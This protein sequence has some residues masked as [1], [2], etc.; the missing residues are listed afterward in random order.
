MLKRGV[1]LVV[2]LTIFSSSALALTSFDLNSNSATLTVF[3]DD[4]ADRSGVSVATG[5]VNND[6]FDD[7]IIGAYLA[8][9][10]G[11]GSAGE[12]YII[13]GSS[14]SP[15]SID[16][17][18]VSA[19]VTI[20]GDDAGDQSGQAVASGDVNN[21][22]FADV[23]IGAEFGDG[24]AGTLSAAGETYVIF[25]GSSLP[26]T[27]DLSIA[28]T[29]NVTIFGD[30]AGDRSGF[31]VATGDVNND[32]FDDIII[33]GYF[34]GGVGNAISA[35]GETY[36]IFG[37]SSLPLTIDLNS[38][39]ANVTIFGDD[40]N[41]FSGNTISSGDV[42]NDGFADVIIGA[43]FADGSAG[44]LST[45][46]ETYVIYGGSSL[47]LTIDL[48]SVSANVTIFGDDAGD[49]SSFSL[50]TGDVNNDGFAD[51]I[52]G[53]QLA[54]PAG[55][56]NAGEIYVIFGSSSLP[57]TIDL[58][59]VSANVTIF[60]DD[61]QDTSASSV[62]SG[63]VNN[64]GVA[65]VIIGAQLADPAGG[66]SAGE[67]YVIFG[68]SSLPLTIDLNSVSAN[69]TIFG[70]D[71][72]DFSGRA[73]ASGDVNG[74]GFADVIIG[75]FLAAGVGN[76]LGAAG[77]TY[78]LDGKC[79]TFCHI[80]VGNASNVSSSGLSGALAV[81][82]D[83]AT[84]Q[85]GDILLSLHNIEFFDGSDLVMNLS[86]NFSR[87]DF[88][89]S[90][91]SIT[92]ATN[93]IV[94]NVSNQLLTGETKT[95]LLTETALGFQSICVDDTEIASVSDISTDCNEAGETQFLKSECA[96]TTTTNGITCALS[97]STFTVSGLSN[98]GMN[99]N[100]NPVPEFSTY[101][102]L[103]ALVLTISGFVVIR[104]R[105]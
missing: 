27:I 9:P 8:D 76:L 15:S 103:L 105:K 77:E 36:V 60:G 21:D 19:N 53:A 54:D 101:A 22:G 2:F 57:L 84:L 10:A 98:S 62:A 56:S 42:N 85:D 104:K 1:L 35:A 102:L 40:A 25:G 72:S 100:P 82:R 31:D 45:A 48:N 46:G 97:G 96:S 55:G 99:G 58:N 11:G 88:D 91:V 37:S 61:A 70:D 17:N 44:T 6:G 7:I 47:P 63:D 92:K 71:A 93:S 66:G 68:S 67:I 24:S 74:D 75:A 50:A 18:S 30:D 86:H 59:S 65:D 32:S 16:L 49:Q 5:D 83:G 64:D 69:V 52:I 39:S 81:N 23:I 38:V 87:A 89:F 95:M 41:D 26:A 79:L 29:A 28:G 94:V 90:K 33:G 80:T 4:S 12:T 3:G 13:F 20:F 34:A 43:P 73:V 51:V 78:M 14:S